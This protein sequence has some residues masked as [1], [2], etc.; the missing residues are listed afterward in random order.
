M[1]SYYHKMIGGYHAAKLT[2]YQDLIDHQIGKNNQEVLN[3]LNTK[4]FIVDDN[5][6][7][8]NT[9]ALG[10]A[11]WV[12]NVEFVNTPNE[13][14]AYLNGFNAG[15]SAVADV[16][17]QH[18]LSNAAKPKVQGDTIYETTYAPNELNYFATTRNG[19]VAV[20]SEIYFPW[21]WKA[22]IDGEPVEIAR[23]NY[24]LRALNVPAGTHQINFKFEPDAVIIAD[25]IA[26]V[27]IVIIYLAIVA[28]VATAI[29]KHKRKECETK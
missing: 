10:N 1:P 28:Y 6:A 13:E 12:E 29:I 16:K 26:Y 11:W 5:R 9:D 27:A 22:T 21:G 23:V 14:M 8:E 4:Y 15:S 7:I 20:F 3:M 25:R 19:G 2:R 18:V 17:Y 24:V